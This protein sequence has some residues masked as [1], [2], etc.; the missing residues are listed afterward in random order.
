MSGVT[1][2]HVEY[3]EERSTSEIAVYVATFPKP[4]S[5][6]EALTPPEPDPQTGAKADLPNVVEVQPDTSPT[7][8]GVDYGELGD[9]PV[10]DPEKE[11]VPA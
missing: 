11:L 6:S 2:T 10:E 3:L 7:P 1:A 8:D 5:Q 9:L 4:T